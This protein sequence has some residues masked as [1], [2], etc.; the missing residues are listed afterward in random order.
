M[1]KKEKV[2]ASRIDP[3]DL[4]DDIEQPK[5][6]CAELEPDNAT[7]EQTIEVLKRSRRRSIGSELRSIFGQS[8][9][10]FRSGRIWRVLRNGDDGLGPTVVS[11]K[12]VKEEGPVVIYSKRKRAYSSYKGEIRKHPGEW[13]CRN[14]HANKPNAL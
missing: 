4:P 9:L 6:R 13:V 3:A 8:N 7:L 1:G 2:V 11:E 10:T 5:S 14:L 12:A